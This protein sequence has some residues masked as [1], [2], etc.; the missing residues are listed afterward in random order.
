[1]A[2]G[3]YLRERFF[4]HIWCPGCGHGIVL[5]GLLRAVETMGL[6]K[7]DIVMVSGIGC[8]SRIAG[9]LD[10][11]TLHT[12]HGRA[13]AFALGVKM[14]R[15]ELTLLVPMGDGD[16]LSIGGN[17]FIH[18]CRRNIDMTAIVMNNRIYGM[19]G[20]Q[21]SPLSGYGTMATTA[22]YTN[23]DQEFDVVNMATAAGATFVA[24]TTAYHVQQMADVLVE[25]IRH[26][27]FS[28]V[29]VMSPCPTY[30]GRK[31]KEGSAVDM[32]EKLKTVTTPIGSK[33]KQ[34][35]PSLIERG[36]FVKKEMPEYCTEYQKIIDRAMKGK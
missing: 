8:S 21:Y 13:L 12:L 35:N 10:F 17:H 7:N 2:V 36:I 5:N 30:F 34:E 19:T 9:Y 32:M 11:H 27:G 6:K 18:A 3:D 16:A 15:P 23:I 28:V 25:A 26:K 14:S 33:A 20:G 31:N 22:P 1:M 29:E 24:R 4:P